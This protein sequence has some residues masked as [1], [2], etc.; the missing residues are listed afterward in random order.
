MHLW[1][2]LSFWIAQKSQKHQQQNKACCSSKKPG[3]ARLFCLE[4]NSPMESMYLIITTAPKY[5]NAKKLADLAIENNMAA[6]AQ[7]QAEC[8]STYRWKGKI[9]TSTEYPVHLKTNE[10]NKQAL[11]SLLKQNHPYDV[12]EIICIKIDDVD[13]DY[14]VWLNTQLSGKND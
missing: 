5:E 14:A 6:C 12:P 4:D 11:M 3:F 10:S 8:L 13:S 9:E 7:I 1:L 2:W